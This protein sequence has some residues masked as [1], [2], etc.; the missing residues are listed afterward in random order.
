[1]TLNQIIKYAKDNNLSFDKEI[2]I[3]THC[4]CNIGFEASLSKGGVKHDE[5]FVHVDIDLEEGSDDRDCYCG[6]FD[7]HFC[8]G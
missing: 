7:C 3:L 2:Q 5:L 1:M 8:G 4:G 6:E